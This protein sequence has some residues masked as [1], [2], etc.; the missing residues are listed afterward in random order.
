[1]RPTSAPPIYPHPLLG[2]SLCLEVL[3]GT[4]MLMTPKFVSLA[5]PTPSAL[6]PR[7]NCLLRIHGPG[8]SPRLRD[9]EPGTRRHD[10][11]ARSASHLCGKAILPQC[12]GRRSRGSS[13]PPRP[14]YEQRLWTLLSNYI[15]DRTVGPRH[16]YLLSVQLQQPPKWSVCFCSFLQ[17]Y[18]HYGDLR[19]P[20]KTYIEMF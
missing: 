10:V 2:N 5:H 6:T 12:S 4:D 14:L 3:N 11:L 8:A 18:P 19:D 20:I 17:V 1:M 16:H 9:P 15:Q 13:R 7:S